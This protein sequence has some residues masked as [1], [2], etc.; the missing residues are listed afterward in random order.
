MASDEVTYEPLSEEE[1]EMAR[2]FY[3]SSTEVPD[4]S[5]FLTRRI[6]EHAL[7][8][9]AR[10][11]RAAQFG[12]SAQDERDRARAENTKLTE[13]IK[14]S[15]PLIAR[16]ASALALNTG[17]VVGISE[18][19]RPIGPDKGMCVTC[20]VAWPCGTHEILYSLTESM[21]KLMEGTKK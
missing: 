21:T 8:L 13:R 12:M 6:W 20:H 9:H 7:F 19:H 5:D 1:R 10:L 2:M 4:P 18:L 17:A 11:E 14:E 16:L 3:T 15:I